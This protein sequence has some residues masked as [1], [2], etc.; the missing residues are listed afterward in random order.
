M[1]ASDQAV[2][3]AQWNAA[4]SA[5]QTEAMRQAPHVLMRPS[6]IQDGNAWLAIYGDLAT[7][8]VG[9]GSTPENAMKDFDA[10]WV[11]TSSSRGAGLID[12]LRE[13]EEYFDSRADAEYFTD[14][15]APVPNE[16]MKLLTIVRDALLQRSAA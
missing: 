16:E 5:Q 15:A 2:L 8:V 13:C 9:A 12:A 4:V 7:G 3:N 11:K 1:S 6:L 10:A 14:S